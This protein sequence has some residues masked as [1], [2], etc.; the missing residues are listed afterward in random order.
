[1]KPAVIGLALFAAVLHATWNTLLRSG[2]DRLW[3][4]TVMSFATT[5]TAIPMAFLLPY[6]FPASWPYLAISAV[7]QVGYS[8][9]LAQAYRFGELGLVYP[10]VR[11]S[12][13]LLVTL[14]GFALA[15]QRVTGIALL[16]VAL[17]SLGILTV[18]VGRIRTHGRSVALAGL[19]ALFVASYITMDGA[20]VRLAGSPQ[21]YTAW[22]F[23]LYGALMPASYLLFRR[24]LTARP[25]RSETLKAIAGGLI[26]LISYGAVIAAFALGNV[27]PIAALR[28]TSVVFS[29]LLGRLVLGE[30]LTP[31]R[32]VA[33]VAV[34]L[35]AICLTV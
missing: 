23:L 22:I 8:I 17:V 28:E 10:L 33:C 18:T 31:R 12:V 30:A 26:S 19:T 24:E 35:G 13:P 25:L 2:V 11:G 15:G 29:V 34:S 16:G 5:I 6:P 21:A 32:V 14:G 4:I 1:M 3:S 27:G 9:L 7:L 20:G